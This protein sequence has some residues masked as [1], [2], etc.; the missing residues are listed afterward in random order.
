M[1]VKNMSKDGNLKIAK[2]LLE[3]KASFHFMQMS[4]D[5]K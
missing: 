5:G 3:D 2:V 1:K 4:R